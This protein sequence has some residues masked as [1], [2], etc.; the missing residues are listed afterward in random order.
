MKQL[1]RDSCLITRHAVSYD[2]NK[3][4]VKVAVLTFPKSAY[5]LGETVLGVVEINE[6]WTRS[7]VLSVSASDAASVAFDPRAVQLSAML[8]AQERL[9]GPIATA[10]NTR[11]MRRVHAEHHAS[12]VASTLR[13]TFSLDIPSD[14][15]PSLQIHIGD[16]HPKGM[17]GSV[18][19]LAWRVR[20]CLLVAVASQG[21]SSGVLLK[22][23]VR[24]GPAGEWGI[25]YRAS[26]TI[27]P[28][29]RLKEPE[30]RT[31]QSSPWTQFLMTSFLGS[32]ERRYHDGDEENGEQERGWAEQEDGWQEIKVETVECDV[33][34][35]VW[36]GN[37]AFKAMDVVFDV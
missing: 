19:G 15:S 13:T 26:P 32:G 20:L 24:D 14:A 21:D 3:D 30:D 17:P 2:V 37:T 9:P 18:G 8:E 16:D 1:R 10:G 34:I 5:R 35:T 31:T 36:P 33:P 25:P 6:P 27:A 7:R 28:M 4:G 22:S 12:F 23:L 29:E 11:H